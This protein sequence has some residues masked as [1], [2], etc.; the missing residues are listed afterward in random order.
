MQ[1]TTGLERLQTKKLSLIQSSRKVILLI[2]QHAVSGV[3]GYCAYTYIYMHIWPSAR[4]GTR[5]NLV[6]RQKLHHRT[7]AFDFR[8]NIFLAKL[9]GLGN[10]KCYTNN[11]E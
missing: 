8:A 6:N 9:A 1:I 5:R 11:I 10:P 4:P 3:P 7:H 2:A